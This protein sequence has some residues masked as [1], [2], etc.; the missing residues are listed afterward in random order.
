[1][2]ENA[3]ETKAVCYMGNVYQCYVLTHYMLYIKYTSICRLRYKLVDDKT[4]QIM[5]K[6]LYDFYPDIS[7]IR[8]RVIKMT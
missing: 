8:D 7:N 6:Q 2:N 5:I 3:V 4:K 1:M